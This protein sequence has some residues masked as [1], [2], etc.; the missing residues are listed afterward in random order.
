MVV[1]HV[2]F[3]QVACFFQ[4][5][6][7]M[8]G[9][10]VIERQQG[11]IRHHLRKGNGTSGIDNIKLVILGRHQA[12]ACGMV[13]D[14]DVFNFYGAVDFR[15]GDGADG[16]RYFL[17]V[18]HRG[19]AKGQMLDHDLA[20]G[21]LCDDCLGRIPSWNSRASQKKHAKCTSSS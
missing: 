7:A 13:G 2:C 4:K 18:R 1:N 6:R 19:I 14:G 15:K 3:D 11:S 21:I 5:R 17:K 8:A 12:D 10:K 9:E 20:G 16:I